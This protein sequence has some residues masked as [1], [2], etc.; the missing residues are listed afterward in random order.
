MSRPSVGQQPPG[1]RSPTRRKH[2]EHHHSR[3]S[4][5]PPRSPPPARACVTRAPRGPRRLLTATPRSG[6]GSCRTGRCGSPPARAAA[7]RPAAGCTVCPTSRV[8]PCRAP[9]SLPHQPSTVGSSGGTSVDPDRT[10][11]T[12]GASI[13][14]SRSRVG[15]VGSAGAARAAAGAGARVGASTTFCVEAVDE[16][17]SLTAPPQAVRETTARRP[18]RSRFIS[19]PRVDRGGHRGSSAVLLRTVA[20]QHVSHRRGRCCAAAASAASPASPAWS[21]HRSGSPGSR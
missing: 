2:E 5:R 12:T 18:I 8:A 13:S 11:G 1:T 20:R 10:S 4:S 6:G 17:G 9:A 3:R 19:Q 21:A 7:T 16:A 14:S 15:V